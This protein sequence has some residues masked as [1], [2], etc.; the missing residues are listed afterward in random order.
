[1]ESPPKPVKSPL[2]ESL[3]T[4]VIAVA[5]CLI[6]RGAVAEPRYIPSESM[7]PTL[8]IWDRLVVEKVSGL[9]ST[10]QRGD[11]VVFYPPFAKGNHTFMGKALDRI[12]FSGRDAYIKRVI[13]LPGET[14]AVRNGVVYINDRPLDHEP[15]VEEP[16][17]YEM[18]ALLIPAG[19]VFVLGDNR[20]HS[21]DSHSW[22]PLPIDHIVGR[23]ALRF[24]PPERMGLLNSPR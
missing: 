23:A 14:L 3:E 9:V 19:H 21:Y 22:G 8:Q 1:M 17:Y 16:A 6:T 4:V 2:R 7:L 5:I 15:Y 10:P 11:I 20:N 24:W 18:A 13:G 12:G